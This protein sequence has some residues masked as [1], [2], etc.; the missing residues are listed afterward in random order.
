M[1]VNRSDLGYVLTRDDGSPV[2][3][4]AR[5]IDTLR[6]YIENEE[7][8]SEVEYAVQCAEDNGEISFSGWQDV[9]YA[10]YSSEEDARSDFV[11]KVVEDIVERDEL[12]DR[13]PVHSEQEIYEYVIDSARDYEWVVLG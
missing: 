11:E 3:L 13:N 12:Y 7:L 10:D 5:E 1:K 9:G 4:S 8:R 2:V 6:S